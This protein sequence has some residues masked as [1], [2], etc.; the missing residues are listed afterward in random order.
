MVS[1]K[2][3]R[4]SGLTA[5]FYNHSLMLTALHSK[6]PKDSWTSHEIL[7]IN[8]ATALETKPLTHGLQGTSKLTS[9]L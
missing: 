8:A 1:H 6:A 3:E 4:M 2:A 5:G 7:A 9:K